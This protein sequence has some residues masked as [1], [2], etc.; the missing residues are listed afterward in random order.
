MIDYVTGDLLK[1]DREALVNSVNCV[2]VMGRGVALAFK[3]RFPANFKAYKAACDWDEVEP[4]RMFVFETGELAPRYIINFPTKRH[5]RANSRL[6]DIEAGLTALVAEI[7]QRHIRSI[8][9]PPLGC[10]L[11]G[12]QWSQVKSLI[13]AALAPLGGVDTLVFEPN[14]SFASVPA[15][16]A[17]TPPAI[18]PGRAALLGLMHRYLVGLGEPFLTLL[19]VHKLM[20]FMQLAGEPLHL[21]YV[22]APHG[23]YAQNLRHVL[24]ILDG[25]YVTGPGVGGGDK[26]DQPL[27]LIPGAAAQAQAYL[28]D[29]PE[30]RSRFDRVVDLVEGF[31][32]PSGLELL[33]TVHWIVGE[34]GSHNPHE[35]TRAT[36]AWNP[37][38]R[39]FSEEQI[40]LALNTL[41]DKGW[42]PE[43]GERSA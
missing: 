35:A 23:P 2:G 3:R 20:Y 37:R 5:W 12:L 4:G 18:T 41:H 15:P 7:E 30:T 1:A 32:S 11:G 13:H 26:P 27:S 29:H 40:V 38:K 33:A 22:K 6:D 14:D 10:G 28:S 17:P 8:A 21:R 34:I 24:R 31:E 9:L 25:V 19:E 43:H 36:Y 16:Q 42:L 39:R